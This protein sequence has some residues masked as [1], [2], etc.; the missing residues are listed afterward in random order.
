MGRLK[1][2]TNIPKFRV[3]PIVRMGKGKDKI[4]KTLP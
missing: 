1:G 4:I 2:F 3:N